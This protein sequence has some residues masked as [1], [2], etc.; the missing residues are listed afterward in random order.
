MPLGVNLDSLSDWS[1]QQMFVDLM[2]TARVPF[3][4]AQ[5]PFDDH[6]VPLGDDGWPLGGSAA[7]ISP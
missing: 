6:G 3:G 2:K 1:P 4:T 7:M 5:D